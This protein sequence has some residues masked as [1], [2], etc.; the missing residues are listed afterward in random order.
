MIARIHGAAGL[1][2]FTIILAFLGATSL[3]ELF[4]SHATIAAVKTGILWAMTALIACLVVAG[5]TGARLARRRLEPGARRKLRRMPI[6]ALNGLLILVPSAVFL[7]GRAGAGVFDAWFY[8][9]QGIELV[10]GAANLFLAGL[11]IRDGLRLSGRLRPRPSRP[12]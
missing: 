6:I 12:A 10:A 11:N 2:A 4:G 1:A 8:A 7:A 9:V 3:S 5:A